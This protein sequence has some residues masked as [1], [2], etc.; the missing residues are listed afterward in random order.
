M[1]VCVCNA[2]P[3]RA[4]RECVRDGRAKRLRDLK[5]ELHI[6]TCCNHCC[7]MAHDILRDELATRTPPLQV[8]L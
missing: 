4:V 8:G 7:A 1:Y 3:E 5:R 2:V 6:A